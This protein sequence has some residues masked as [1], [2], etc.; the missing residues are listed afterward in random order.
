LPDAFVDGGG[1]KNAGSITFI[2]NKQKE[3]VKL[4]K[5]FIKARN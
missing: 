1:H 4:I 2:P 3:I 5:E